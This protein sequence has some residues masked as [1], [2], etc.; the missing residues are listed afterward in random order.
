[1]RSR[2]GP[3]D[4]HSL[5]AAHLRVAFVVLQI[6]KLRRARP[7]SLQVLRLGYGLDKPHT[8]PLYL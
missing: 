4:A 5:P 2:Y 1:M 7:S 8:V 3:I 6:L